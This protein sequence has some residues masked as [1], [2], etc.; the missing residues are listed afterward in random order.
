MF[1]FF[2]LYINLPVCVC[3]CLLC[4][5]LHCLRFEY[6]DY[7]EVFFWLISEAALPH[8][9]G[10]AVLLVSFFIFVFVCFFSLTVQP[11]CPVCHCCC[12]CSTV[13]Y[14]LWF[15]FVFVWLRA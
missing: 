8:T 14:M 9:F 3:M 13:S 15:Q 4:P 2:L 12:W 1:A 10:C 7:F 6:L 5:A 11:V